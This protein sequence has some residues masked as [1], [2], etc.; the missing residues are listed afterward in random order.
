V[1]Q[2]SL[3]GKKGLIIG[4]ANRKSIAYG[5]AKA[6]S[7]AGATLALTYINEKA[8]PYV[9]PLVSELDVSHFLP[10]DVSQTGQLDTVF[11]QLSE[12]WGEL[13]FVIH[14]IAWSPLDELHG[15]LVDSSQDGFT[16][17]MD[18]S[19]HSFIRIANRA[20]K[21]MPKGGTLITMSYYGA[22]KVV[23]NYNMMGPIKAALES[24]V[25]YLAAELGEQNIRVHGVSPGPMPTRAASGI[26]HFDDLIADAK[27]RSPLHT[28]GR[29]EDVGA[30]THFLISDMAQR[31][32]GNITYVDAGYHIMG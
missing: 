29:P 5:C 9:E 6:L 11:D 19:C 28:L 1:S 8:K 2:F 7:D 31:L 30:L 21:L 14:S 17:A 25:R 12:D 26:D 24:S 20:E 22:E 3:Q 15:R 10:L 16:Q 13:D 23:E 18:I 32:T 27:D 4:V